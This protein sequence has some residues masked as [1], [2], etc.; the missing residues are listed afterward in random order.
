MEDH[1]RGSHAKLRPVAW[2]HHSPNC[3]CSLC[4]RLYSAG[5]NTFSLRA[6]SSFFPIWPALLQR[7]Q[8]GTWPPPSRASALRKPSPPR[9]ST[10]S[11]SDRDCSRMCWIRPRRIA[12]SARHIVRIFVRIFRL[13]VLVSCKA[14]TAMPKRKLLLIVRNQGRVEQV[15]ISVKVAKIERDDPLSQHWRSAEF[16]HTRPLVVKSVR[17]E[18]S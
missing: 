16:L 13:C 9:L 1:S 2:I 4:D 11:P 6:S 5:S 15:W 7:Q 8:A 3:F 17:F 12:R 10:F 14:P 18:A